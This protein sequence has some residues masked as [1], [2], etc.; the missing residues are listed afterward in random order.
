MPP[1]AGIFYSNA[2]CCIKPEIKRLVEKNSMKLKTNNAD[3]LKKALK[4][5]KL[6]MGLNSREI[7][8]IAVLIMVQASKNADA[9]LKELV[10]NKGKNNQEQEADSQAKYLLN[11][12]SNMAKSISLLMKNVSPSQE[13]VIN[14]LK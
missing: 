8:G 2:M 13:S 14:N 6:F 1:E 4:E 5:N 10:L 12:K 11:Y 9:D 7:D 3:S